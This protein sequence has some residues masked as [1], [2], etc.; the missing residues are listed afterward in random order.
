VSNQLSEPHEFFFHVRVLLGMVVSL[1]LTQLLRGVA[2][3]IE[4]PK[5]QAIYWVH[6]VWALSTFVYLVHFWW[7]ELLLSTEQHWTFTLCLFLIIYAL[8][9]YLLSA[10]LFPEQL[11]D[12]RDYRDYFF[13]RRAWFFGILALAYLVDFYDTWLKGPSHFQ[14]LG[15]EYIVRNLGYVALCLVAIATPNQRFHGAF[16]VVGLLYQASWI[17]RVYERL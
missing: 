12:Y 14:S 2:R 3:I 13:S 9:L 1:A 15:S 7:W 17:I 16:A 8:I 6:A 5:R 11:T 10:L 4:H